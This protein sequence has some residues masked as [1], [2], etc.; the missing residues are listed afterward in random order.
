MEKSS[1]TA[2]TLSDPASLGNEAELDRPVSR[3]LP[4]TPASSTPAAYV[5][6]RKE[7][8]EQRLSRRLDLLDSA[9]TD[10]EFQQRVDK[11]TLK[12]LAI[13]EGVYLD[14]MAQLRSQPNRAVGSDTRAKL[15]EWMQSAMLELQRRGLSVTMT[16]RKVEVK[17]GPD[18]PGP[19]ADTTAK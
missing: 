9:M 5:P 18:E 4:V 7:V 16:E 2:L 10:A 8:L 3:T 17:G 15:G 13:V 11:A 14:K 12:D 6:V 19:V 1:S